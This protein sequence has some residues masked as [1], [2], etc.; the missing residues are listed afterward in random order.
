[1]EN[2]RVRISK[3]M[4][5]DALI[6]LLEKKEFANISV[7]EICTLAG[8]NRTTFYRHYQNQSDLLHEIEH[9]I[10]YGIAQRLNGSDS[11]DNGLIQTL[12]YLEEQRRKCLILVNNA[13]DIH[14]AEK[15]FTLPEI[16][17]LLHEN[18]PHTYNDAQIQ[19]I[20]TFIYNGGYSVIRQWLSAE[21]REPAEDMARTLLL[22]IENFVGIK[23]Q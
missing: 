20:K 13:R 1:M 3:Q 15:I 7:Q 8:I 14:F 6:E 16:E 21:T 12:I 10:L 5:K 2:Q 17:R 19:Y 18:L 4:L 22:L 11:T 9:D 23:K